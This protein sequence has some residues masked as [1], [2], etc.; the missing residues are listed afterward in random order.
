MSKIKERVKTLEPEKAKDPVLSEKRKRAMV[1]YMAIMFFVAFVLVLLS[2]IVQNRS[3]KQTTSENINT[4]MNLQGRIENLQSENRE[5][6]TKLAESLLINAKQAYEDGNEDAFLPAMAEI[7]PYA[8][9][10]SSAD[11]EIYDFLSQEL[12][13]ETEETE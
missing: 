12:P 10:L 4:S 5:L 8:D 13:G 11:R 6:R 9:A 1:E 7:E 2:L 3:L